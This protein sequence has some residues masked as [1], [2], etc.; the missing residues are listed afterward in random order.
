MK[1]VTDGC[2]GVC[3]VLNPT[4][5]YVEQPVGVEDSDDEI[6]EK[7]LFAGLDDIEQSSEDEAGIQETR[8]KILSPGNGMKH[9][10]KVFIGRITMEDTHPKNHLE[11]NHVFSILAWG[12]VVM[13]H[14]DSLSKN[15]LEYD[16]IKIVSSSSSAS[17]EDNKDDNFNFKDEKKDDSNSSLDESKYS[18]QKVS[19]PFWSLSIFFYNRID[20]NKSLILNNY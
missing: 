3:K 12:L 16:I 15:K 4:V 5:T 7:A 1:K 9:K 18:Q 2:S 6:D 19:I 10:Q 13:N 11:K 17:E 14:L 8:F 20:L